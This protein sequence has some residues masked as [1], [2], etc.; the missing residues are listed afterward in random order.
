MSDAISREGTSCWLEAMGYPKLAKAVMDEKRFPS[1]VPKKV[2]EVICV[3]CG[4]R[5]IS[6]R[7][8]DTLLKDIVCMNCGC[9]YVIETGEEMKEVTG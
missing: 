8:K 9:G 7:P 1:A 6:V 3:K 4:K 5:W 2:S